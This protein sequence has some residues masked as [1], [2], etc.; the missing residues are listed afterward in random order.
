MNEITQEQVDQWL[1]AQR[2]RLGR[3][4]KLLMWTCEPI[5]VDRFTVRCLAETG[6]GHTH[7][8][9]S[10]DT[11]EDAIVGCLANAKTPADIA[12]D[13][14]NQAQALIAKAV[15]LEEAAQ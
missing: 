6:K 11:I 10:A 12:H 1:L 7:A 5:L 2:E 8:Q 14:R 9:H 15:E 4:G 13:L 3:D